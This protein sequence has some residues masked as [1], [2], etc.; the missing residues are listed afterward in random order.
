MG[1]AA[2]V[3]GEPASSVYS[4]ITVLLWPTVLL[5]PNPNNTGELAVFMEWVDSFRKIGVFTNADT[6]A[7]ALVARKNGASGIGLVR[8]GEH[9]LARVCGGG[10]WLRG[11]RKSAGPLHPLHFSHPL[12]STVLRHC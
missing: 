5:V 7:D 3:A 12:H 4:H 9:T 1:W 10:V 8:T 6:P 2:A 11:R